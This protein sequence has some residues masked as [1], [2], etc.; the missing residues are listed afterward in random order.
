MKCF[1]LFC[2]LFSPL[3][4]AAQNAIPAGAIL[5]VRLDNS[6]RAGK[7]HVGQPIHARIMQNIPGTSIH[8]GAQVVGRILAVT[9]TSVSL[10]FNTVIDHGRRFPVST[11]LRAVASM[12]RVSEAYLPEEQASRGLVPENWDTRQI[13][14]DTVYRGGGHVMAVNGFV[15][16]PTAYGVRDRLT[17]N[18]P[19]RAAVSGNTQ[20]QA[21]WL[22]SSNACGVYDIPGLTIVHAGRSSG[23]IDLVSPSHPL[24]IRSGSGWLLRV[25]G[26]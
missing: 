10:R 19:C 16:N 25:H 14:G 9:P 21:L 2:A 3:T 6:L 18:G 20:P 12:M 15:G 5:P 13:G 26:S 24:L 17:T 23:A 22:F 4:V 8:R 11:N 7:A 1:L